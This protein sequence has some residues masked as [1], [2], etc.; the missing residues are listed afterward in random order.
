MTMNRRTVLIGAAALGAGVLA[1]AARTNAAAPMSGKQAPGFYR[2]KV[3]DFEVT[4]IA[5]GVRPTPLADNFVR[6]QA[7]DAVSS[8]LVSIYPSHEKDRPVFPFTFTVVNTGS[9]L[10][11]IDS[12][13]GPTT[14]EQSKGQL[15]QGHSNLVAA[16]FDRN[17]VDTVIISHFHG[18]HIGGLLTAD[19]KPAFPN[20][21]VMVPAGEWAYWMDDAKM[22]A[23]PEAARG[24]FANARRI[25]G[26]LGKN[27]TR[28]EAGKELAPGITGIP[29]P[30]HTRGHTSH[31]IAS[32]SGRL[33]V[34]GDVTAGPALLFFVNPGWHAA[35]DTDGPL[36]E[37]SRRK[38]YEMASAENVLLQGYHIPFPSTGHVAK[39]GNGYRFVPVAWNAAL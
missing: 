16:G 9:K 13:L 30:G 7:K 15:G 28:Y 27:V 10:V 3:G 20:A 18:D 23:A 35:F 1:P 29:T 32:G 6:N 38:L 26:A 19:N 34:Q 33:L 24:G 36:A 21:E 8:A 17:S 25:F 4:V 22:N 39:E 37:Q 2:Y 5:D 31:L 14:F 12:G 11:L